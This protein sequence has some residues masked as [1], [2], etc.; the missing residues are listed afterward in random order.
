MQ[1]VS[2]P[3]KAI[4]HWQAGIILC[5]CPANERWRLHCN[6]VSHW[7]GAYIER[8]LE[9]SRLDLLIQSMCL[10][11]V[12]ITDLG[13]IP[14]VTRIPRMSLEH[15][16][17][18]T[19]HFYQAGSFMWWGGPVTWECGPVGQFLWLSWPRNIQWW[20]KGLLASA[21]QRIYRNANKE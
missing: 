13:S 15:D 5:M 3:V 12:D 16:L 4:C 21:Y 20:E 6:T 14:R 17:A 2:A 19:C 1:H 9:K 10:F 8:S 11:L 18:I 7:L